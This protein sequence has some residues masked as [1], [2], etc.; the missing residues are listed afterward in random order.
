MKNLIITKRSF[1]IQDMSKKP[2]TNFDDHKH[3]ESSAGP[4]RPTQSLDVGDPAPLRLVT[5]T[6][7]RPG[8]VSLG[9]NWQPDRDHGT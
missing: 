6:L 2:E 9:T 7:H 3:D 5:G 8:P 4:P 1:F